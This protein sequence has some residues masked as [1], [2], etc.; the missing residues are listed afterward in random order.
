MFIKKSGAVLLLVLALVLA[1][2]SG[3]GNNQTTNET[4]KD[5]KKLTK[6]T[7]SEPARILSLAPF[8][9]AV[10]KG[11]LEEEGIKAE[12]AS[13]GGGSQVIA[14]L[15][16]GQAQ[17]AISGPR[18]MFVPLE[19]GEDLVAIQSL[20]SALTF[21]IALSNEYMEEKNINID[22]PLKDRVAALEGAS[23]GTNV[24][25]DSGD[26]YTRYLMQLHGIDPSTVKMVKLAGTGPKIGGMKEGVVSGGISSPP[27]AAQV[28]DEG[29][30][31]L[32]IKASEEPT[33]ANMVWEVVFADR[34]YLKEN[35]DIAAKVVRAIGKGIEFTRENPKE[36]AESIASY[37][38]GTDRKVLEN[39]L[40]DLKDT[41][42]GYGEMTKE[43]WDNAQVPLVEF[44][45]LTGITKEQDT[46]PGS[47]WTNEYIEEAF[48]E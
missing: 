27:F 37:F 40:I 36:A 48:P 3:G 17:F 12:I 6:I 26:I 25:G 32:V 28:K 41:F 34:E 33:Y 15:L 29:V 4:G 35:P 24:V 10:E 11:F 23:I 31:E 20:N 42:Q 47:I 7:F 44:G 8:Y 16:S 43:S 45:D 22:D 13:G 30:G 5:G 19:K 21:E 39:S 14:S 2:C 18:S 38:E 1:G 9:A 46:E